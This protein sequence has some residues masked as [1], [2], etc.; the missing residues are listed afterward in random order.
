[1][2]SKELGSFNFK[3][4]FDQVK[5]DQI[6]KNTHSISDVLA[7]KDV[8]LQC[9]TVEVDESDIKRISSRVVHAVL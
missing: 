7:H 6:R 9:K 8:V 1:M 4:S 2:R 3:W 5:D